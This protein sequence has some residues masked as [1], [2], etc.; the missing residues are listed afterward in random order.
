MLIQYT[1][2][3]AQP[4]PADLRAAFGVE[5]NRTARVLAN[6]PPAAI[7]RYRRA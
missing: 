5:G 1:Y 7:W 6:I 2:G 3:L 4:V